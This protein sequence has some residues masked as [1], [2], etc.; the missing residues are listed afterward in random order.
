[1]RRAWTEDGVAV[2]TDRFTAR[3]VTQLPQPRARPDLDRRQQHR[4]DA[5]RGGDRRRLVAVPQPA[6]RGACGED[7]GDHEPRRARGPSRRGARLR[8]Q[9]SD[10]PSRSPSASRRSRSTDDHTR[11]RRP[12]GRLARGAV[13]RLHDTRRVARPARPTFA[14]R[15]RLTASARGCSARA[16]GAR[17]GTPAPRSPA[18][19]R[20]RS[21]TVRPRRCAT[22]CS[23]TTR[24]S[25]WRGR[26]DDRAL[27]ECGRRCA[28]SGAPPTTEV[29]RRHTSERSSSDSPDGAMKSSWPPMPEY[30]RPPMVSATTWPCRSTLSAPLIVIIDRLRAITSGAFTTSTGQE[31]DVVVVV[32]PCVELGGPRRERG[33]RHAVEL[34]LV[35][36]WSPCRRGGGASARW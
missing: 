35:A 8:R 1:M 14:A 29:E 20:A 12:R 32:E 25:W 36:G 11:V 22:P 30:C 13:R 10:A 24:S 28:R 16:R 5:A 17:R 2:E 27:G 6:G 33:H 4:G 3:G 31:R 23:V 19:A 21:R 15:R 9:R 34:P 26:R 18:R 7:A